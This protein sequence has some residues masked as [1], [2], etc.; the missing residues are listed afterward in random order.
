MK[1]LTKMTEE[2]ESLQNNQTC[3]LIERKS[4]Q[5]VVS[6]KWIFKQKQGATENELVRFKARLVDRG[7]TKREGI[8]YTEVFSLVLKHTSIRVLMSIV[9]L[10]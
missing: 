7:Y 9:A 4:N 1:W 2:F 10:A 5:K 8:D 6:C 3:V